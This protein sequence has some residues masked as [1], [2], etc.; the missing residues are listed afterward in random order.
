MFRPVLDTLLQYPLSIRTTLAFQQT[1]PST[2]CAPQSCPHSAQPRL[3]SRYRLGN[4]TLLSQLNGFA[5]L[6]IGPGWRRTDLLHRRI[7]KSGRQAWHFHGLANGLASFVSQLSRCGSK[8]W[9][10]KPRWA[11]NGLLV[12]LDDLAGWPR[13]GRS[14]IFFSIKGKGWRHR[15][16]PGNHAFPEKFNSSPGTSIS[17]SG[18][19]ATADIDIGTAIVT[20]DIGAAIVATG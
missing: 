16:Q 14:D 15:A 18:S 5:K 2:P 4:V 20:A 9:G 8:M 13:R 3:I 12:S 19:T 11:G 7:N 6:G 1:M 10:R 17:I